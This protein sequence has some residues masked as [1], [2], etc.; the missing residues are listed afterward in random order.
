M[1]LADAGA[2]LAN[3]WWMFVSTPW[4]VVLALA[5]AFGLGYMIGTGAGQRALRR[6]LAGHR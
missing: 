5:W 1:D 3:L 4:L 2:M 6:R